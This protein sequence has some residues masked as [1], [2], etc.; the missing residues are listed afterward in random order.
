M[1]VPLAHFGSCDSG[2]ITEQCINSSDKPYFSIT[3]LHVKTKNFRGPSVLSIYSISPYGVHISNHIC[4]SARLV[5]P[6]HTVL[7]NMCSLS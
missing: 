1:Q 3:L 5:Q 6:P 7:W 2:G 4:S